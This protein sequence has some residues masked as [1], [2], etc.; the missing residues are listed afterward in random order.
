MSLDCIAEIGEVSIVGVIFCINCDNRDC[1]SFRIEGVGAGVLTS[2]FS[3]QS[4]VNIGFLKNSAMDLPREFASRRRFE[5]H[6]MKY[7]VD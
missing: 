4:Q 6:S 2:T 7:V 3:G 1:F 5:Q